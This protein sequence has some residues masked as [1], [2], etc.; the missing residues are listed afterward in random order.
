M[1]KAKRVDLKRTKGV[2]GI[3]KIDMNGLLF[4]QYN[5]LGIKFTK[6]TFVNK[7][8]LNSLNVSISFG[9]TIPL[10]AK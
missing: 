3:P 5:S 6:P 8:G 4:S 1:T 10:I 2:T 9:I 7:F